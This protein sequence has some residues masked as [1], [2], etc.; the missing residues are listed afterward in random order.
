MTGADL[1]LRFRNR[2]AAVGIVG[3]GYVGLP[4]AVAFAQA[5][6]A[7]TALDTDAAK[8]LQVGRGVSH[9]RDVPSHQLAG[10]VESGRLRASDDMNLLR[11]MDAVLICVPTPLNKQHTPDLSFVLAACQALAARLRRG[12]LA[13]LE[14]TTYPGT[15]EDVIL[16]MLEEA[17]GLSAARDF[18]LAFCAERIDPGN[19]T[20]GV[21]DI[22]RVLGATSRE[23]A[24]AAR[25][26]YLSVVDAVYVVSSPRAAEM[27]KLLENTFRNVNIALVNELATVCDTLGVNV[28][29]VV[30]AAAT[31]P[32]GFMSFRPGPGVG[33]HCIPVDPL[34]LTWRARE[35]GTELRFVE[36]ATQVNAAMPR[37]VVNLVIRGL[38]ARSRAVRGARVLVVGVAYKPDID[39]VRESPAQAVIAD[40]RALG[41]ELCYTDPHVG[42]Y[43]VDGTPVESMTLSPGSLRRIDCAVVITAHSGVDYALLSRHCPVVVDARGVVP[44]SPAVVA[45]GGGT[46]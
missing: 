8:V 41:A 45:L 46:S 5:G 32:F 14:S 26:L 35:A 23:A 29:E 20:Y 11:A 39:D 9:I 15:T 12:Q 44:R 25:E 31:K 18:G 24:E 22:P 7:V 4:T 37:H 19:T 3:V 30:D 40:L 34:Y 13:I 16:P 1:P 10:L 28:W 38:N 21:R 42:H 6:Y 36:L 17:S 27:T 33:G 43:E 2:Q